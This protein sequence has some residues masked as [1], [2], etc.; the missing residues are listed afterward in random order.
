MFSFERNRIAIE[1]QWKYTVYSI[2][3]NLHVIVSNNS[4]PRQ[5]RFKSTS[6][7]TQNCIY[8]LTVSAFI[9]A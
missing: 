5:T 4:K 8:R 1:M 6:V 7:L 3:K 9:V 2:L